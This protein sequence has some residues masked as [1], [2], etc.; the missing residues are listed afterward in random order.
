[1]L[2]H[3][4]IATWVLA[5]ATAALAI[6]GGTA[7]AQ[8]GARWNARAEQERT[9]AARRDNE[10]HR[11]RFAEVWNWQR[12]QPEGNARVQAARWYSEWTG[13]REPGRAGLDDG[14]QAPG[15]HAGSEDEASRN[16]LDFLAAVYHPS[17]LGPPRQPLAAQPSAED[18]P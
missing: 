6:E 7:L 12:R 14:S 8:W 13:A 16:Y 1:M 15:L 11:Q 10:L 17:R 2:A 5:I 4:L 3:V 9:D 18:T